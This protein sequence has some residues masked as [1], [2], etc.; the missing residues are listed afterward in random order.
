VGSAN[1]VIGAYLRMLDGQ[2]ARRR[3]NHVKRRKH[4]RSC[5]NKIFLV[6]NK[7]LSI[8]PPKKSLSL[9]TSPASQLRVNA[10]T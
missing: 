5:Y 8:S 4:F 7:T 6:I 1:V 3:L 2:Q 10:N 9:E